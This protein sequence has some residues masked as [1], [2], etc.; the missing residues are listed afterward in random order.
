[1]LWNIYHDKSLPALIPAD[2]IV[3]VAVDEKSIDKQLYETIGYPV[4][5][6]R[7]VRID[8]LDRVIN[9]VYENAQKGKFQA[10]HEMAEWLGCSIENLYK[11]L[12]SMGHKKIFD[13]AEEKTEEKIE[14][15]KAEEKAE[16][17]EGA[18]KTDPKEERATAKE[19]NDE[20]GIKCGKDRE[21]VKAE[22]SKNP[23][24]SADNSAE[25]KEQEKPP[26]AIFRL[27]KGKAFQTGR[28]QIRS[29]A[30]RQADD[31]KGRGKSKRNAKDKKNF[32]KKKIDRK[33]KGKK[34]GRAKQEPRIISAEAKRKDEDSPF[35]ILQQLKA[36]S[37]D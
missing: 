12:E 9:A 24:D 16:E 28:Q 22:E 8:M 2:G 32:D 23:T 10:R 36:K 3:S 15:E 6:G 25:N 19:D 13:P 18:K 31:D 17:K 35:A 1:M 5:G 11:V 4:Y 27:K 14:V 21:K 37:K 30:G 20:S 7:A 33:K 29:K 26:L 34:E